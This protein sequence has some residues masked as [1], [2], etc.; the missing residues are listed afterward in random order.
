MFTGYFSLTVEPLLSLRGQIRPG[1]HTAIS[2]EIIRRGE[3]AGA[4]HPRQP[5]LNI[6]EANVSEEPTHAKLASDAEPLP[7]PLSSPLWT[8]ADSPGHTLIV[9]ARS[10]L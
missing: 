4:T 6:F 9:W 7:R 10:L 3:R 8:G 2:M 5:A 1:G